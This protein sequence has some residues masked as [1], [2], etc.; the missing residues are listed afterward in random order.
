MTTLPAVRRRRLPRPLVLSGI[1]LVLA[2]AVVLSVCVGGMP[3]TPA[4]VMGALF[5]PTGTDADLAITRLRLPRTLLGI[6]V[7][8]CLGLAGTLVQGHTR[9]PIADPGLLGIFQG[10]ALA[11]VLVAALGNPS[12]LVQAGFAFVG[13]LAA[14]TLVFAIA[15][16]VRGGATPVT[17]VLAGVA[18]SAICGALVTAIVLVNLDALDTLR[19]WQVGSLATR[20][21]AIAYMWPFAILGIVLALVNG[22]ALNALALG[23][24]AAAAL[25]VSRKRARIVGVAAITVLAGT[26]VMLAG[27]I[28]FAGLIVPHLARAAVGSDYRWQLPAAAVIGSAVLILA[29]TVGRVIARPGELSV[30]VVLAVVGAPFFIALARRRRMASL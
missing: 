7:G 2:L 15:S 16:R 25:G 12:G 22:P 3:T 26:A 18:V 28:A 9:N 14:S 8:A 27:P 6:V 21:G 13:A 23:P 20:N 1:L 29:D 5:A 17:L 11:V 24:D 30:S 10:A 19:F 4:Q